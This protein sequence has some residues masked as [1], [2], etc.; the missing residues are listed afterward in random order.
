MPESLTSLVNLHELY[1]NDTYIEFL[2]ANFGRLSNLR[3]LELRDNN[4]TTLPKS[5]R[6][7][8]ALRR[9]D[10]SNNDFSEM[11]YSAFTLALFN[12]RFILARSYWSDDKLKRI[13]D[14]WKLFC[15]NR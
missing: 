7:L 3:I 9:L 4:L 13:M 14:K 15:R 10:I 1:L 2:P 8:T 6:R 12:T 11:V 5:L